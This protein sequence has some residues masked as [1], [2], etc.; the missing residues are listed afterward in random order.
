VLRLQS[1]RLIELNQQ[2]VKAAGKAAPGR[3]HVADGGVAGPV[4]VR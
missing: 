3:T 2:V 4:A 1:P